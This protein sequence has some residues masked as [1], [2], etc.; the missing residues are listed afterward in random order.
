[1]PP[2]SEQTIT[3]R[4]AIEAAFEA[5]P[6]NGPIVRPRFWDEEM[7][8]IHSAF[9]G[10][11]WREVTS[12]VVE[13]QW[14]N[15]PLLSAEAQ[16]YYIPAYILATLENPEGNHVISTLM[17]LEHIQVFEGYTVQQ[18]RAVVEFLRW[19]I[20]ELPEDYTSPS[21]LPNKDTLDLPARILIHQWLPRCPEGMDIVEG[22]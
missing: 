13:A 8:G 16:A 15:L 10:K 21:N 7:R 5:K 18:C 17:T 1:M 20:S 19:I 4:Q 12:E 9:F 2:E 14:D 11:S 6:F 3:V 22:M